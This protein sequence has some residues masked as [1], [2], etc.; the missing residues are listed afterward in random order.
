MRL[1]EFLTEYKAIQV[2]SDFTGM[3]RN[4]MIYSAPNVHELEMLLQKYGELRGL[5]MPNG[6]EFYVWSAYDNDHDGVNTFLTGDEYG[7]YYS[8][9]RRHFPPFRALYISNSDLINAEDWDMEEI[10]D[11]LYVGATDNEVYSNRLVKR[12]LGI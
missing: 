5:L 10:D 2:D 1:S 12:A 8:G 11:N 3:D 7:N 4:H 9:S 6:K